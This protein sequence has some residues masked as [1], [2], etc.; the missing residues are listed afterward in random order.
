M[1]PA[2]PLRVSD[3]T[4][5]AA[6]AVKEVRAGHTVN[7]TSRGAVVAHIV[8]ANETV[9]MVN[10]MRVTRAQGRFQVPEVVARMSEGISGADQVIADRRR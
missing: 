9:E 6:S 1:A 7:V 4:G 10:G 8:P 2:S 3:L 5:R